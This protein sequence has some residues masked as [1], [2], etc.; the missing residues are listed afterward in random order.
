MRIWY[1]AP[2]LSH[3]IEPIECSRSNLQAQ[4]WVWPQNGQSKICATL[5][6]AFLGGG[7]AFLRL[8]LRKC[9]RA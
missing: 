8:P 5:A 3:R 7:L 2:Q 9:T 1:L 4:D 6:L